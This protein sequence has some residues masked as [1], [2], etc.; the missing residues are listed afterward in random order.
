MMTIDDL[1][2][3]D[4]VLVRLHDGRTVEGCVEQIADTT[5][6]KKVRVM[7]GRG[8]LVVTVNID[9]ILDAG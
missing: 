4:T 9:Q 1:Q 6:G 7:F 3:G 2:R 5:S 8:A